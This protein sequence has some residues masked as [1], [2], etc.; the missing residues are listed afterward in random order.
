MTINNSNELVYGIGSRFPDANVAKQREYNFT[1]TAAFKDQTALLTY[2]MNGTS[3][4]TAPDAG[5]GT[6]IATL[7]LTFTNDDGDILDI[8]LTEIHL[9]EETLNQNV[10]EVV[11]EGITGWARGLTNA[12]YTNDV[13]VAPTEATN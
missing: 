11:K 13:Q 10:G 3:S 8:N 7:E 2:F 9:D 1:L 5:S 6:E 4:A 12:V